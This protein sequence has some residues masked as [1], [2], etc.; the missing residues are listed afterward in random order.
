MRFKFFTVPVLDPEAPEREL[1]AFLA[2][3]RSGGGALSREGVTGGPGEGRG[4]G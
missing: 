1:N 2:R 3:Q 4:E